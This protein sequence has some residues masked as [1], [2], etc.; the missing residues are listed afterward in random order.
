MSTVNTDELTNRIAFL[1]QVPQTQM[2]RL[3]LVPV[4]K[5]TI[6]YATQQSGSY[7]TELDFHS[8]R[9]STPISQD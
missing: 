9:D 3:P 2:P 7:R 6:Q 4:T 1:A 8:N 5:Y